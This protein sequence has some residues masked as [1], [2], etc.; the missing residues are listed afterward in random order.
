MLEEVATAFG[1]TLSDYSTRH[2]RGSR[3]AV[4]RASG[5]AFGTD[6][7]TLR[8]RSDCRI[9]IESARLD[10]G[11][12]PLERPAV[13]TRPVD[14]LAQLGQD[15]TP[16]LASAARPPAPLEDAARLQ[17]RPVAADRFQELDHPDVVDRLRR[18]DR[19]LPVEVAR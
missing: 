13:R 18:E 5:R 10:V 16:Q 14:L 2:R 17:C 9:G 3:R 12:N 8:D 6:V 7:K 1:V 19:D 11:N 15:E 4:H